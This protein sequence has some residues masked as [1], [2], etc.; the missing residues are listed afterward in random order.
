MALDALLGT[1]LQ[2]T[3]IPSVNLLMAAVL[4]VEVPWLT[5]TG[6]YMALL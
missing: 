4:D 3:D 6:A 5:L 2:A 1:D